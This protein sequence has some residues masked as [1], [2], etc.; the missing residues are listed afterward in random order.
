M[1]KYKLL[2]LTLS[3]C[4]AIALTGCGKDK[5]EPTTE[6][7][8]TAITTEE[9]TEVTTEEATTSDAT[10]EEEIE[11]DI[12]DEEELTAEDFQVIGYYVDGVYFNDK[13]D[14]AMLLDDKWTIFEDGTVT[15]NEAKGIEDAFNLDDDAAEELLNKGE[16]IVINYAEST[17]GYVSS[18]SLFK[19]LDAETGEP[20]SDEEIEERY[21]TLAEHPNSEYMHDIKTQ[22]QAQY[23]DFADEDVTV[24][25]VEV[26]G[27]TGLQIKVSAPEQSIEMDMFSRKGYGVTIITLNKNDNKAFAN[28]LQYIDTQDNMVERLGAA[29]FGDVEEVEEV[30]DREETT[31][32][33]TEE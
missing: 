13:L 7:T 1:R 33:T 32:E 30:E 3:L 2:P 19:N 6:A 26:A 28:V 5:E 21:K 17:D 22:L 12:E 18:M 10:T 31:T 27:V 14:I 24:E 15:L 29:E 23:G 25:T 4:F 11:E 8:T 16:Y 20:V 9:V